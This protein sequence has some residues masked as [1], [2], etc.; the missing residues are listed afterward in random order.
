MKPFVRIEP[1]PSSSL[2]ASWAAPHAAPSRR[3]QSTLPAAMKNV[4][5]DGTLATVLDT[6]QP[7][8]LIEH[9]VGVVFLANGLFGFRAAVEEVPVPLGRDG[10]KEDTPVRFSPLLRVE[11][12]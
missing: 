12:E 7:G 1:L 8:E 10:H 11:V 9:R 3:S 4:V 2:D 6:V 5:F